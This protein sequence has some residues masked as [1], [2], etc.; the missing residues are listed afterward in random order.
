MKK[1]NLIVII[2]L[3]LI[4]GI[5]IY[6]FVF[7]KGNE[8]VYKF[9][10]F[11]GYEPGRTYKGQ[12]NLTTGNADITSIDGCSLLP[13]NCKSDLEKHYKGT[14][15]TRYLEQIKKILETTYYKD[16]ER[17]IVSAINILR[18]DELCINE[19]D[20]KVTCKELAEGYLFHTED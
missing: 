8:N 5:V 17:L 20:T 18:N 19:I 12:I 9:N 4:F 15:E 6:Y 2:T 16:N 11:N 3:I 14:I 13:E 1:N 7:N 10:F